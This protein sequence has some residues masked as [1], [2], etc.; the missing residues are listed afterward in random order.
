MDRLDAILSTVL[1]GETDG[2]PPLKRVMDLLVTPPDRAYGCA[3]VPGVGGGT[4]G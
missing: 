3:R 1:I 4:V 2:Y